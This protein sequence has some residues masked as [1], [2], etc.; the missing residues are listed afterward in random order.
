MRRTGGAIRLAAAFVLL[1]TA[2]GCGCRS[3]PKN[4]KKNPY[5]G[6]MEDL[7]YGGLVTADAV[8]H[9]ENARGRKVSMREFSGKFVWADYG[10]PWCEA[11]RAQ[12]QVIRYLDKELGDRIV[13]LTVLT[14][15]SPE[16]EDTP[17]RATAASWA[18]RYKLDPERV[19]VADNLWAWTIPKNILFSPK[20]QILYRSTGYLKSKEIKQILNRYVGDWQKWNKTGERA[21]WMKP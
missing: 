14:S 4:E 3:K 19:L 20:G 11:C 7:T 10:G 2:W 17:D 15:K 21:P 16:Y 12:A 18:R 1:A 6:N 13:F 8:R 5:V 9:R